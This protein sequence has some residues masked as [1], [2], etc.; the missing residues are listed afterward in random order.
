MIFAI[1]SMFCIV[2]AYEIHWPDAAER[3][4]MLHPI[5]MPGIFG[6]VDGTHSR[7]RRPSRLHDFERGHYFSGYKHYH[8]IQ[9]QI[10]VDFDGN[11][12]ALEGG[13]PGNDNDK[14]IYNHSAL[15]LANDLQ[16]HEVPLVISFGVINSFLPSSVLS[17]NSWPMAGIR[18]P[19]PES[20]LFPSSGLK[21][22]AT[23]C[24]LPSIPRM[25]TI[26]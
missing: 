6:A 20:L 3:K 9:H 16:S 7:I 11:I 4:D 19:I 15:A 22:P 23:Q 2:C 17:R 18:V 5:G 14:G 13:H 21:R 10:V 25:F 8:T 12:I 26:V 1:F 24:E